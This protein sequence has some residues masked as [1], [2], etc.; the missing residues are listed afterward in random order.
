MDADFH[1]GSWLVQPGLN[2]ISR[3]G[4]TAQLE[5][6]MMS[7]LVCLAE[8]QGEPVSKE[9]LLQTVWPDTFVSE[10]VLVRSISEL[11]RVLGDDAKEPRV[12]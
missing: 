11:R 9:K 2:T 12:I 6:K 5:P 1:L 3:N 7:V 8:H 10:G 4:T